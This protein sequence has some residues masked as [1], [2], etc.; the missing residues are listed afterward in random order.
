MRGC[1]ATLGLLSACSFSPGTS[2]SDASTDARS[3]DASIDGATATPRDCKEFLA[4]HPGSPDGDYAVDPEGSGQTVTVTCDM[5]TIGGGWTFVLF[6]AVGSD[7]A[8]T[9]YL[10][11][12]AIVKNAGSVLIA[13]RTSAKQVLPNYAVFDIPSSWRDATPFA[14]DESTFTTMVGMNGNTAQSATIYAGTENF[15]GSLCGDP[16]T[17][18]SSFGRFCIDGTDAPFYNGFDSTSTDNCSVSSESW[19]GTACGPERRFSMAVR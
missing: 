5:K 13:Y 19:N 17:A 18:G 4:T 15:F 3:I 14:Q 9:D 10:V 12:A 11:P 6:P 7:S 8:P 1:V 16:W 2:S